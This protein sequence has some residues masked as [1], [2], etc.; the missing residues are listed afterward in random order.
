MRVPQ[1]TRKYEELS[2]LSGIILLPLKDIVSRRM[3]EIV[4]KKI[5]SL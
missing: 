3:R 1:R 5:N 4:V 2:I